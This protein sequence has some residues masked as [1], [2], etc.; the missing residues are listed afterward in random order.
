MSS[1]IPALYVNHVPQVSGAEESLLALLERLDRSR[2][3]PHLPCPAGELAVRATALGVEIHPLPAARFRRTT[4][5]IKVSTYALAW[6]IGTNH[7]RRI[8]QACAPKLIHANSAAA[9]L[10][11]GSVAEKAGV[12]CVWHS[13]DLRPLPLPALTVCRNATRVIAVS[14]AVADFLAGSGLIR[15]KVMRVYNGIDPDRWRAAVTGKDARAELGLKPSDRVILMAAQMVPWKR[16][17]DA[18]RMMPALLKRLPNARLVLAGSDRFGD[19]PELPAAL[20]VLAAQ[21]GVRAQVVFAGQRQDMPDLMA[22]CEVLVVPS[23]AEPF[24]RVAIE[25][26]ALG[27]PVVGTRAGGLPEIVRDGETGLLVV[28]RFP[29]SLAEACARLLENPS[30][31]RSLGEA[32]RKRVAANFHIDKTARETEAAYEAALHP[33]LKWIRA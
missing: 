1:P 4:N 17:E 31:A 20:E 12:P 13:R 15:P 33:P 21:L 10:Y 29:E 27:K 25:A 22:A 18:I 6:V 5:P 26:M 32:G 30:L 16:H 24:G 8:V 7:L 11:A 14:E 19:P 2:F 23:D 3:V 28:P 9:Q